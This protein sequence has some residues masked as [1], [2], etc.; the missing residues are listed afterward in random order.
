MK[1]FLTSEVNK[2]LSTQQ[3]QTFWVDATTKLQQQVVAVLNGDSANIQTVN[4]EVVLNLVPVLNQVL[5]NISG[6]LELAA[7]QEHHAAHDLR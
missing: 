3:F 5:A 2:V 1:G 6:T 4:G 7:G